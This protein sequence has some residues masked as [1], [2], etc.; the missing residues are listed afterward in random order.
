MNEHYFSCVFFEDFVL[1]WLIVLQTYELLFFTNNLLSESFYS[2][3]QRQSFYSIFL[4]QIQ[5]LLGILGRNRICLKVSIIVLR[6]AITKC[7][8]ASYE[9]NR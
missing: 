8:C 2:N 7:C 3:N 6:A 5:N 9:L 4:C 1:T